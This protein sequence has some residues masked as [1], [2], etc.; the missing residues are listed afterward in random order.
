[1]KEQTKGRQNIKRR[2]C[3]KTALNWQKSEFEGSKY[4]GKKERKK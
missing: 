4:K 3:C 2:K 1:M